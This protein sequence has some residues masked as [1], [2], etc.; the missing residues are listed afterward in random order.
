MGRNPPHPPGTFKALPDNL[1][2]WFSVCNLILTQLERRPQKKM[3]DDLKKTTSKIKS[4]LIGCDIIEIHYTYHCVLFGLTKTSPRLQ[5]LSREE[6][7]SGIR[8]IVTLARVTIYHRMLAEVLKGKYWF[9]EVNGKNIS[10]F[11]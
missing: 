9:A 11:L 4:T 10:D 7:R 3:E 8:L 6:F 5:I 1:G 2:S